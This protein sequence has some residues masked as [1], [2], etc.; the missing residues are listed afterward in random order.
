M[1]GVRFDMKCTLTYLKE[2]KY[3]GIK[4]RI[5]FSE[6]D[7]IDFR[8][9]H[10]QVVNAGIPNRD[11]LDR[12]MALDSDCQAESFCYTPMVPVT[13]FEGEDFF[14]FIRREG[15]YYCFE[16]NT[17][18]LGPAWFQACNAYIGEHGLKIDR[19]FDMEYYPEG[20]M[21]RLD[22][23]DPSPQDQT[24]CV[25]FRKLHESDSAMLEH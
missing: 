3:M 9:L 18:E 8:Q 12:F 19:T 7:A 1:K 22:S 6:H 15:D 5:V 23:K 16:V 14:R 4:T 13:A 24:I 2:Q 17:K 10:A 20:Y 11:D 21:E 25:I